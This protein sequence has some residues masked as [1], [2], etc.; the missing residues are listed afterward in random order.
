RNH[1]ALAGDGLRVLEQTLRDRYFAQPVHFFGE[2][3]EAYLA[4]AEGREDLA[5]HL[6]GR[7]RLD[8]MKVAP[9]LDA[10]RPLRGCRILEIGCGTGSST[11]AL[12]EQGA[13]VTG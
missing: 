6:E 10:T 3:T 5:A 9:W 4:S 2:S 11:V 13:E 1:Q 7:L 12:A 8:R